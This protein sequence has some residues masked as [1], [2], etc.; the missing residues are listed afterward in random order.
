MAFPI[1]DVEVLRLTHLTF[2]NKRV[3]EKAVDLFATVKVSAFGSSYHL[4]RQ[5]I[6]EAFIQNIEPR[7]LRHGMRV[8]NALWWSQRVGG[9]DPQSTDMHDVLSSE[10]N[11]DGANKCESSGL[12]PH[13][14]HFVCLDCQRTS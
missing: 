5:K 4:Q 7:R 10:K 2:M 3:V 9:E 11:L 14:S 12:P 1:D 8:Y 6:E 13:F